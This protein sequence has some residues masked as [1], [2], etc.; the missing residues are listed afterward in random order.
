MHRDPDLSQWRNNYQVDAI[1][2]NCLDT[3][4]AGDLYAAGYLYGFI[5]ELNPEQCGKIG[6][7]LAGKVIEEAGA[8]I[9]SASWEYIRNINRMTT[10]DHLKQSVNG[11]IHL[12]DHHTHIFGF[13]N[14]II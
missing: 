14:K 6:S 4:G 3:T 5:N 1:Q 11:G 8:K 7:L 9:G 13:I 10:M 2:V 12:V